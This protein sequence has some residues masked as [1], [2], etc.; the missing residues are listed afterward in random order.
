MGQSYEQE[1][2][3]RGLSDT[4]IE[5]AN[6]VDRLPVGEYT[7]EIQKRASRDGGS[8]IDVSK[9]ERIRRMDDNGQGG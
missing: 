8:T 3:E 2:F 7:I 6:L 1:R 9:K 4:A 5:I